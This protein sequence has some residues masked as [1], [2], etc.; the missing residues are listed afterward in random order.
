MP[1][2]SKKPR[3]Y[4]RRVYLTANTIRELRLHLHLNQKQFAQVVGVAPNTV[5]RWEHGLR[6]PV[7]KKRAKLYRMV[8]KYLKG[9]GVAPQTRSEHSGLPS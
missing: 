2:A 8:T 1:S 5:W 4:S 7:T 9:E 6:S 3:S